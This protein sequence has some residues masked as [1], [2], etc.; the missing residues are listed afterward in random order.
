MRERN[1]TAFDWAAVS[2][3]LLAIRAI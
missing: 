3:T 1:L 2:S